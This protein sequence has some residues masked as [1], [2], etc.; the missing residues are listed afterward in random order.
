MADK[1]W[2][3]GTGAWGTASK[4]S[5]SSGAVEFVGYRL[6][7]VLTVTSVVRGTLAV[8]QTIYRSDTGV[9]MG[10]I[11]ALGTGTGGTGTYTTSASGT[12]SS[13]PGIYMAGAVASSA[14]TSADNAIFDANSGFSSASVPTTVTTAATT[15]VNLTVSAVPVGGLTF[16]G[17]GTQSIS[18]SLSVASGTVWNATGTQT[19]TSTA[20]GNTI[21]TNG[22]VMACSMT[23]NGVGGSWTLGSASALATGKL[24]TMTQGSLNLG[25]YSLTC[26]GFVCSGATTNRTLTF[27]SGS[28]I[29]LTGDGITVLNLSGKT[30]TGQLTVVGNAIFDISNTAATSGRTVGTMPNGNLV[31]QSDYWCTLYVTGGTYYSSVSCPL[32]DQV[33]KSIFATSD[34]LGYLGLGGASTVGIKQDLQVLNGRSSETSYSPTT[35][36]QIGSGSP[37]GTTTLSGFIGTNVSVINA[38]CN[39]NCSFITSLTSSQ[40][41]TLTGNTNVGGNITSNSG[42]NA[43]NYNVTANGF[44]S[45]N[46]NT[47]TITM[48]SGTWTLTG[49]GTVWDITDAT[50]LTLNCGTSTLSLTSD[51]AKTFIGGGKTY[52]VINQT[53]SGDPYAIGDLTIVGN[54][55][56]ANITNTGYPCSVLFTAGSTNTFGNF[57]L[58]GA[59]GNLVTISSPTAAQ[60]NLVKSGGG[61]V[62]VGY[63][64]I[65]YSNA[66]PANTWYAAP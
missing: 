30:N 58:Q 33:W 51:V 24:I 40:N 43:N 11:T 63:C 16:T 45:S 55:T 2:V 23:L 15:V 39:V 47:R 57:S 28:R 18:G 66:S 13:A 32:A 5:D 22:V 48:G 8:G 38:P 10:T 64:N 35:T 36:L 21:S 25:T 42:F 34:Y 29:Y 59:S 12:V 56:F 53:G 26:G 31:G 9:S 49:S 17:T 50:G 3:G 41:I 27:G 65:S 19:F 62:Q 37:S 1:Y 54:N 14:P 7:A 6:A 20:S 44:F 46:A 61:L 4:W 60:H 52:N